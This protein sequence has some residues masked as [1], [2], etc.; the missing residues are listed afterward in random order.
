M[1]VLKR[2]MMGGG[3]QASRAVTGGDEC[4]KGTWGAVDVDTGHF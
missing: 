1:K 3:G 4:E 2:L